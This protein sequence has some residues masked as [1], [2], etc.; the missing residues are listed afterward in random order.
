MNFRILTNGHAYVVSSFKE[1]WPY[2]ILGLGGVLTV[3]W[4]VLLSWIPARLLAF[5]FSIVF[6]GMTSI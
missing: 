6:A 4:I 1:L 3:A 2:A 5:A